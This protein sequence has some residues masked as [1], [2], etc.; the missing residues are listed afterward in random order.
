MKRKE[1]V[2]NTDLFV[3][4]TNG[5]PLR[6]DKEAMSIP[7]FS[8]S[9]QKRTKPID[10]QSTDGKT[11]VKVKA[12]DDGMATIWDRDVLTWAISQLN[13][14]VEAKQAV[15]PTIQ[16]HPHVMLRDIGRGTSG[17]SYQELT[18]ALRRL[19]GT[20]VETNI[21]VF[22]RRRHAMFGLLE[23]WSHDV[24]EATGRSL[25]M[26][27]TLPRWI[28]DGVVKQRDVL[29]LSPDYFDLT[30]GIARW[31]YLLARRHAGKQDTGWRFTMQGLHQRSGSTRVMKDFAK[32]V[33]KIVKA[34]GIPEYRLGVITGQGGEEVVTMIRDPA[35]VGMPQRRDLA[36][37]ASPL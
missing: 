27:I 1:P 28:F 19:K 33:R 31:L 5:V 24:D 18:D 8:L 34:Q 11:W 25:G 26:Q 37:L 10:W 2:V 6:E 4:F 23:A 13:A 12:T 14:A 35:K 17:K 9:K 22:L 36:G 29:A 15:T 16:F 20:T 3:A 7:L 32:D 21:R 30:S